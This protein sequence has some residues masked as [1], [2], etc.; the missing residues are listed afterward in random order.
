MLPADHFS[1]PQSMP[2]VSV[3]DRTFLLILTMFQQF[4]TGVGG[5]RSAHTNRHEIDN[6]AE[7]AIF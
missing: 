4:T 5:G 6:Y 2:R 7:P 1:D 3:L